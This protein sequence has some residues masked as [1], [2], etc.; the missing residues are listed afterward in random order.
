VTL[1]ADKQDVQTFARTI[2]PLRLILIERRFG[3]Q[4]R[5]LCFVE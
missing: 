4:R 5:L 2:D 3:S 1:F